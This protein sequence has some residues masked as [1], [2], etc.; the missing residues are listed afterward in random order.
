MDASHANFERHKHDAR[1]FESKKRMEASQR[2]LTGEMS[3]VILIGTLLL[4]LKWC[5][6][7]FGTSEEAHMVSGGNL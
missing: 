7:G 4:S 6:K 5:L 2:L 3:N 1:D